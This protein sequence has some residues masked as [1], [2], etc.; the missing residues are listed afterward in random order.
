MT[1]KIKKEMAALAKEVARHQKLYYEENDPVITDGEYDVMYRQLVDL[2]EQY[3]QYKVKNSPTDNIGGKPSGTFT[4]IKH[5]IPMLSLGNSLNAADT[6]VFLDKV[7]AELK[8]KPAALELYEELKYDGLSCSATYL[9]GKLEQGATRGD[10]LTGEDITANLKT[11]QNVP[12]VINELLEV[13]RF[14]IRGEVLMTRASFKALNERQAKLGGK[15]FSNPRNAAAGALRNSDPEI[16]RERGLH[17]YA[18][19]LGACSDEIYPK[20]DGGISPDPFGVTTQEQLLAKFVSLGFVT[21]SDLKVVTADKVLESF[22]EIQA[23][24]PDLPYEIDGVVYKVNKLAYQVQLGWKSRTPEWATAYKFPP[25]TAETVLLAIDIQVGRTGAQAPVARVKPVKCGGVIVT[26]ITL[27]NIEE[28]TRKD[29]RIGDTLL[30][31]RNGDVIPGVSH[32]IKDKRPANAVPYEMPGVCPS[33]GGATH[34]EDDGAIT[35]CLAGLGCPAQVLGAISHY[36]SRKAM[37]IDGI[38]DSTIQTLLDANLIKMPSDLYSLKKEDVLGLEGF[39]ESSA[40]L[41]VNGVHAI[42]KPELRRFIYALGIP[43]TGEGTSKRLA[44]HFGSFDKLL[45]A[46]HNEL[47]AIPD[48]G[49]TTASSISDYLFDPVT[50]VEARKLAKILEPQDLV[51]VDTSVMKLKGQTFLVTGTLSVKRDV[52]HKLIEENGGVVAGSVNKDLN[53]LLAGEEAGSKLEKAEKLN[54]SKKAN[55]SIITEEIF[56]SMIA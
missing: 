53:Y 55:I 11:V 34:K 6:Q 56:R 14:E 32:V 29:I 49:K 33:C 40:E 28:I 47:M 31:M 42:K 9:Y 37:D 35:Y 2:E 25:D 16:T 30:I 38:G 8:I 46:A 19:S 39:G 51:K 44:E 7:C 41:L 3:P 26:N 50:G 43:N 24:R 5:L 36:V 15:I 23:K 12:H 22:K 13:P 52:I 54:G 48:I 10:G 18:Y 1:A 4:E 17:F 27:H 21:A 20:V 45:A